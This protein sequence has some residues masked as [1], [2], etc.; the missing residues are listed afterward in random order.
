VSF[1]KELL[2]T[3]LS[4]SSAPSSFDL[5]SSLA[6]LAKSNLLLPL[7]ELV[8]VVVMDQ[9]LLFSVTTHGI[10]TI[11]IYIYIYP[12]NLSLIFI[13]IEHPF[14]NENIFNIWSMTITVAGSRRVVRQRRSLLSCLLMRCGVLGRVFEFNHKIMINVQESPPSIMVTRNLWFVRVWERDCLCK[15]KTHEPPVHPT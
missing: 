9:F 15:E 14:F 8:V 11:H 5:R 12:I 13:Y 10:F 2:L 6:L 1:S 4:Y 3:G 7:L